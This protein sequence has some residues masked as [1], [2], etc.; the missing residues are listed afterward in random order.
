[1]QIEFF[2]HLKPLL[3]GFDLV[4][5][6]KSMD[7]DNLSVAVMTRATGNDKING[8]PPLVLTGSVEDLEKDFIGTISNPIQMVA[9]LIT[10]KTEF[11]AAVNQAKE[12]P[13]ASAEEQKP[14]E[15]AKPEKPSDAKPLKRKNQFESIMKEFKEIVQAGNKEKALELLKE[16]EKIAAVKEKPVVSKLIYGLVKD[17][18]FD[19]QSA[20]TEEEK[21][22]DNVP[23]IQ[24]MEGTIGQVLEE[25]QKPNEE[26]VIIPTED[27]E[28]KRL[29]TYN[30]F[31]QL[32]DESLKGGELTMAKNLFTQLLTHAKTEDEIQ[33]VEL[34]I[35]E[36]ENEI[37]LAERAKDQLKRFE[38]LYSLGKSFQ[39]EKN[40]IEAIGAYNEA[41]DYL[42][43][44]DS[45][46]DEIRQGNIEKCVELEVGGKL[47]QDTVKMKAYKTNYIQQFVDQNKTE[48]GAV[49]SEQ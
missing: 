36:V 12:T 26:E 30:H 47:F 25:L 13:A 45:R 32:A 34:R 44:G 11:E 49:S 15:P 27:P 7:E 17:I 20:P 14:V 19:K 28:V 22:E 29:E 35:K 38:Y 4:L 18:E 24:T 37:F 3:R 33:E 42:E 40:Y 8:L 1:M 6:I 31:K 9:G 46:R 39:D 23:E 43:P 5:T 21:T 16:A 2:K 10:N 48:A 41:I